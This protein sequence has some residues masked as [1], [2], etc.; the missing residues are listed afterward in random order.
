MKYGKVDV[1]MATC[2]LVPFVRMTVARRVFK[3]TTNPIACNFIWS[4][5]RASN[6]GRGIRLPDAR[7]IWH[8]GKP[9]AR[10]FGMQLTT[11]R[12]FVCTISTIVEHDFLDHLIE[13]VGNTVTIMSS[14]LLRSEVGRDNGEKLLFVTLCQQVNDR[15]IDVT[16]VQYL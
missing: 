7:I 4:V 9:N 6:E 16:I 3:V 11:C 1:V 13:P 15:C 12:K 2:H 10:R 14:D 5:S 8:M